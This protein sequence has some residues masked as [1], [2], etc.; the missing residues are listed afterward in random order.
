MAAHGIRL[1]HG[2]EPLLRQLIYELRFL[3]GYS[4][5]DRCGKILNRISREQPEWIIGDASPQVTPLYSSRNG[6]RFNFSST[7]LDLNLDKTTAD[8]GIG[9]SEVA[10]FV[11]QVDALSQIVIDELGLK[12]FLRQGCRAVYL[13]PCENKTDSNQW[14]RDLKVFSISPKIHE[15]F[16]QIDEAATVAI[17]V[18]GPDCRY[19]ISFSGAE[20]SAQVNIGTELLNVRASSLPTRQREHMISNLQA[21]RRKKINSGF[22]AAIDIDAYHEEP[23][24]VDP[25]GFVKE[26]AG[27]FESKIR[28][29]LVPEKPEKEKTR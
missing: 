16:G 20:I 3:H 22:A 19:R 7:R 17:V 14:L 29:V 24:S 5:L 9:N 26:N 23:P 28:A 18:H 11:E 8:D 2:K 1:I 27:N 25:P 4:Y 15:V 6:C 12:E 13:F 10:E 21:Q